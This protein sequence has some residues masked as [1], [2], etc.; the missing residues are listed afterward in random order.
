MT[1]RGAGSLSGLLVYRDALRFRLDLVLRFALEDVAFSFDPHARGQVGCRVGLQVVVGDDLS[2]VEVLHGGGGRETLTAVS[3]WSY[4][5]QSS[6]ADDGR[7]CRIHLYVPSV[8][9][10]RNLVVTGRQLTDARKSLIQQ[11]Y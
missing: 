9:I 2:G 11:F 10:D 8:D 5:L 3:R 4:D 7:D 1:D 6:V